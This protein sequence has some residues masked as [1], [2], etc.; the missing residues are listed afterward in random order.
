M[1]TAIQPFSLTKNDIALIRLI[2]NQD[3]TPTEI[4]S[5]LGIS[6]GLVSRTLKEVSQKGFVN[7][8][9]NGVSKKI[10]LSNNLH[11]QIFSDLLKKESIM[12]LEKAL[13]YSA[14]GVLFDKINFP[15]ATEISRKTKW[16]KTKEL[17][18]F[19]L[20][21]EGN[22][23]I[24]KFLETYSDYITRDFASKYI[25]KSAEIIWINA[26]QYLFRVSNNL[27]LKEP[28]VKTSLSV[29]PFFGIKLVSSS[30][31]YYYSKYDS[32]LTYEDYVLHTL[33]IE[34]NSPTYNLYAILLVLKTKGNL[35]MG[36]LK[37][38]A[39]EYGIFGTVSKMLRYINTKGAKWEFPLPSVA[40]FQEKA[41]Q[42]GVSL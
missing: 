38:K 41:M 7:V 1:K 16:Q 24:W 33:L 2:S 15:Y 40:E 8:K 14:L 21:S 29:F 30:D 42:Y 17:N 32:H 39:K 23:L 22:I 28:F 9:R 6:E 34:P 3:A 5:K 26:F 13:S 36:E 19:G 35:N 18:S 25:P 27:E 10:Q 20:L 12:P 4:A 11:A 31:Y 37:R